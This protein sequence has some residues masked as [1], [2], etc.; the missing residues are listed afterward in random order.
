MQHTF[1]RASG[2]VSC[3]VFPSV[4]P[5]PSHPLPF[6]LP[7]QTSHSPPNPLPSPL[8][9]S[10][11]RVCLLKVNCFIITFRLC[12]YCSHFLPPTPR[13]H[14][15]PSSP[16]H[17]LT[18]PH[19][20]LSLVCMIFTNRSLYACIQSL[21]YGDTLTVFCDNYAMISYNLPAF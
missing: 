21:H 2:R 18:P 6:S 8:L 1:G 15:T 9:L 12:S 17:H 19:P 11:A 4:C 20:T 5:V 14:Q 16:H 13:P 3:D 7:S 10:E